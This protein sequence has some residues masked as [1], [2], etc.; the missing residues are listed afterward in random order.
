MQ[1]PQLQ[2]PVDGKLVAQLTAASHPYLLAVRHAGGRVVQLHGKPFELTAHLQRHGFAGPQQHRRGQLEARGR[3]DAVLRGNAGGGDSRLPRRGRL[4]RRPA[5]GAQ[6]H[7]LP[8]RGRERQL[9]R[10]QQTAGRA[11]GGKRRD[12]H[13]QRPHQRSSGRRSATTACSAVHTCATLSACPAA[14]SVVQNSRWL[15]PPR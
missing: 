11:G 13:R 12:G 3:Q 2:R 6:R 4:R 15:R 10:A 5:L 9:G 1:A 7:R 8:A 14:A